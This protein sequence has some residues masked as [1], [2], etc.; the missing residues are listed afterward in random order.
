MRFKALAVLCTALQSQNFVKYFGNIFAKF[1]HAERECWL[2][3][4]AKL[5]AC[6][7]GWPDL[8]KMGHRENWCTSGIAA[9]SLGIGRNRPESAGIATVSRLYRGCN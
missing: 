3:G 4:G 2:I 6:A 5:A 7:K 1:S 9:L 8:G